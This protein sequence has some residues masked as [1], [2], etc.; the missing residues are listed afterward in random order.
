MKKLRIISL[1][2]AIAMLMPILVACNKTES[3]TET[4]LTDET[5][6]EQT[7]PAYDLMA[8][9]TSNGEPLYTIVRSIQ[10]ENYAVGFANELKARMNEATG[11]KFT[12][13]VDYDNNVD[14]TQRLEIL[15][16][17][18]NRVESQRAMEELA[19]KGGYIVREDGNKLVIAALDE[20]N[21]ALA[22][23][24]F[25]QLYHILLSLS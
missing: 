11:V 20:M 2:M 17:D 23:T 1:F 16:G 10:A 14:N 9:F 18:T 21:L 8:K 24:E 4:T 13:T 7:E 12:L 6:A 3:D 15:V 19:G 25:E 22:V 5:T